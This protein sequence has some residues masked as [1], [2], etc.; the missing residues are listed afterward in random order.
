MGIFDYFKRLGKT[1]V[2]M[3]GG[4]AMELTARR[5]HARYTLLDQSMMLLEHERGGL[6][7][8]ADLSF[9]GCLV[10]SVADASL[11][12]VATPFLVDLVVVGRTFRVEVADVQKRNQG[13][14]LV[15]R[16]TGG[17]DGSMVALGKILEPLRCGSSSIQ[18]S[19]QNS[20]D[21]M[22][23]RLRKRFSGEGPF[24]LLV[25]RDASGKLN[26]A[27]VTLRRGQEYGSVIWEFGNVV[28]KLNLDSRGVGARMAQ[29]A[30]PDHELVWTC[31]IACLGLKFQ[32]GAVVARLL[33]DWLTEHSK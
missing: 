33:C 19:P 10:R 1:G 21:V 11:D 22:K 30:E 8:V 20:S 9:N 6:F 7:R 16:H 14:G 3:D 32:E 4:A 24:D 15:F 27:M 31:T 26:F 25:E 12:A 28:T 18:V 2:P 29:T 23:S 13:W 17:S 5:Y